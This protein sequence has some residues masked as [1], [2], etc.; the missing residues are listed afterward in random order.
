LGKEHQ[1]TLCPYCILAI[2]IAVILGAK[3]FSLI[4]RLPDLFNISTC[5]VEK[6]KIGPANEAKNMNMYMYL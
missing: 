5:N 3:I 2:W 6:L 1:F 4:P